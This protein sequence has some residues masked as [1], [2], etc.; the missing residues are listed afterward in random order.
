MDRFSPNRINGV[1]IAVGI[2]ALLL[3][4]LVYLISR[5]PDH[6]YFVFKSPIDISLSKYLP[7]F[8]GPVG[9]S[10][11][12]FLHVF[13]FI[14]IT[15]GTVSCRKRGCLAICLSWFLV[16]CGFEFG[17]QFSAWSSKIVP[18]WFAGIPFLENTGDYFRQGTF[19]PLDL[20]AIAM[21]AVLSYFVLSNTMAK[22]KKIR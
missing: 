3:G 11:P 20:G 19:D 5:S 15:A 12:S 21:G 7:D 6:T 1:Q 4:S 13:S 8:F 2:V 17:Q 14:L 10:L 22:E 18:D 9:N 16:D